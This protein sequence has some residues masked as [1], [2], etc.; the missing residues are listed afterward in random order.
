MCA[1]TRTYITCT[2]INYVDVPKLLRS[3]PG[4]EPL[5]KCCCVVF[6][7]SGGIIV[8]LPPRVSHTRACRVY[9]HVRTSLPKFNNEMHYYY[10]TYRGT[11][12]IFFTVSTICFGTK[13]DAKLK[14]MSCQVFYQPLHV[15][16]DPE[17]NSIGPFK[18]QNVAHFS[19]VSLSVHPRSR[20]GAQR[21]R[22][23]EGR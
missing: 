13:Y 18:I 4:T 3:R 6:A 19:L 8:S 15:H 5:V 2:S 17:N 1:L 21:I 9:I 10:D 7:F 12:G 11:I 22:Q 20:R 23:G 14:I 16:Q